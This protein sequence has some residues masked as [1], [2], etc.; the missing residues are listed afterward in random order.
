MVQGF[1]VVARSI[2][3][4]AEAADE[5]GVSVRR[6]WAL[7]TRRSARGICASILSGRADADALKQWA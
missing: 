1:Y 4:R 2:S 7:E 5:L 3:R 6:L